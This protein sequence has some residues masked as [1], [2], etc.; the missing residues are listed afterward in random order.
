MLCYCLSAFLYLEVT[1]V[2]KYRSN[3]VYCFYGTQNKRIYSNAYI[4]SSELFQVILICLQ[5]TLNW[6]CHFRLYT[7]KDWKTDSIND[8]TVGIGL[9]F[10]SNYSDLNYNSYY[11]N[12]LI[13][14][15]SE[16]ESSYAALQESC[17]ILERDVSSPVFI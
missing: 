10:D 6:I 3:Y 4:T 17:F 5:L 1:W 7:D 15:I 8:I 2:E 11:K 9:W 16:M 12:L 14:L 13:S